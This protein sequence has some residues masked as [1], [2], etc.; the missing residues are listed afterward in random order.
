MSALHSSKIICRRFKA[1]ENE[2]KIVSPSYILMLING[3]EEKIMNNI[4]KM[5]LFV[6]LLCLFINIESLNHLI[7]IRFPDF[8]VLK[9]F[10]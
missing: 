3:D 4:E 5:M 8:F 7:N 1:D 9:F 10:I 2:K 6:T